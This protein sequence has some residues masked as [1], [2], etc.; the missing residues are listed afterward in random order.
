M[1][2]ALGLA[3][4]GIIALTACSAPLAHE[5]TQNVQLDNY[6]DHD[7]TGEHATFEGRTISEISIYW[8]C[9]TMG[10]KKC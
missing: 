8:D 4:A 2:I 6:G 10:N 3:V 5:P 1:R 7:G 9:A